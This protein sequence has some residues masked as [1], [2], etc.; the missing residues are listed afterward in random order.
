[1]IPGREAPP[2]STDVPSGSESARQPSVS[3]GPL[4]LEQWAAWPM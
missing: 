4:V 3:V 2:I 1:M